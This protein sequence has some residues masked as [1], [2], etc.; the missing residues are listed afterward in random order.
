MRPIRPRRLLAAVLTSTL[1]AALAVALTTGHSAPAPAIAETAATTN[2]VTPGNFTGYGFDQCQAPSQSAMDAWL[3]RSP[4]LAVGIYMSGDSRACRNQTYLNAT[5]VSTQLANG[6]KLLPITLGPQASCQPRFPRYGSDFKIS[7]VPG[8]KGLYPIAKR[9]GTAEAT[10]TV[11]N[12][13]ALGL[14]PG[15]TMFY[16]LEGF[17][18]SN[19]RCRLSALRFL[20]AWTNQ[21]HKLGYLSGVYSSGGSGIT[22]LD[23]ARLLPKSYAMPD[24]LWVADWDHRAGTGSAYVT[25]TAWTPHARV[26]Q[27]WG[28]HDET[29][30][31]VRINVDRDFADLGKGTLAPAFSHCLGLNID[32]GVYPALAP[33]T[34][35]AKPDPAGVRAVKCLLK[36]QGYFRGRAR[37]PSFGQPLVTAVSDFQ[38]THGWTPTGSVGR[39]DWVALLSAGTHP[40]VKYGSGSEDVRA[41]QRALDAANPGLH[42][43]ITGV[44][45]SMTSTAVEAYQK[46]LHLPVTGVGAPGVWEALAAGRA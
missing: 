36:E 5:W 42:L 26:K 35:T 10:K 22:V 33:A 34:A 25:S 15:S 20:S 7:P 1:T 45:A 41:L 8:A 24:Q 46:R 12:A 39:R 6:W 32:L 30:G 23:K 29:Y 40:V 3:Q 18:A 2:P 19:T 38:R 4:Y 27:Y 31:G 37:R 11:T 21:I 44:F 13:K 43:P 14:V 28:G 17:D 16:D 9:E